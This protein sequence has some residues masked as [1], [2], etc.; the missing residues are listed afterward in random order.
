MKIGYRSIIFVFA[1]ARLPAIQAINLVVNPCLGP[2]SS[3]LGPALI[4]RLCFFKS[5]F[6]GLDNKH[7]WHLAGIGM[8]SAEVSNA[9]S[10]ATFSRAAR[11]IVTD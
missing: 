5:K 4:G 11:F 8:W 3:A 2:E 10:L 6:H 9:S 7:L 1:K